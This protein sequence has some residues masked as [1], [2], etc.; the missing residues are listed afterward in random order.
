[1]LLQDSKY[2]VNAFM[3]ENLTYFINLKVCINSYKCKQGYQQDQPH[4]CYTVYHRF[5]ERTDLLYYF[6]E[7]VL[8]VIDVLTLDFY[9]NDIQT[10]VHNSL[11]KLN[12]LDWEMFG[13][14]TKSHIEGNIRSEES[15]VWC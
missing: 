6:N 10:A 15:V 11:L 7:A 5:H 1:M 3:L 8:D 2:F 12:Y 4:P 13:I 14:N 9:L